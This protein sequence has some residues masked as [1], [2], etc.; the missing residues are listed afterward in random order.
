[1]FPA[2]LPAAGLSGLSLFE[3]NDD[4]EVR[5]CSMNAA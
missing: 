5:I 2:A 4:I 3:F 1:V